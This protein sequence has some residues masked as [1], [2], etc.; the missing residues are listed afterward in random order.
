MKKAGG[1]VLPI[2]PGCLLPGKG[3]GKGMAPSL[4]V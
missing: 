1:A 2:A 4:P 3:K